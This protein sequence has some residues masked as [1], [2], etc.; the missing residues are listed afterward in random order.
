M[1]PRDA[2]TRIKFEDLDFESLPN[3]RCRSKVTL[4][5]DE[6]NRFVG[7]AE[8]VSSEIGMLRCA[9]EATALAL[10][11]AVAGRV[12]LE[13]LGVTTIKAFDTVVVVASLESHF[14]DHAQR[15]VGSSVIEG[16]PPGAAVRA[17][18]SAT[19]RLLGNNLVFLR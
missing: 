6:S 14:S 8:G 11:E 3:G 15:V 16:N 1:P 7:T 5:W 17:V 2:N 18:L 10:E 12:H 4:A 9:A 13:L 19:N